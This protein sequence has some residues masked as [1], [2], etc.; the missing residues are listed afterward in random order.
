MAET[1][2]TLADETWLF[3]AGVWLAVWAVAIKAFHLGFAG[4]PAH[5][6]GQFYLRALAAISYADVVFVALF[7]LGAR[8][9][10]ALFGRWRPVRLAVVATF[11]AFAAFLCLYAVANVLMF[12]IFGGFITY[13]LLAIV[14]D[15]RMLRSSVTT[16]LR[17]GVI[18]GLVC[19]PLAYIVLV[20]MSHRLGRLGTAR[21]TARLGGGRFMLA[22]RFARGSQL[23][24]AAAGALMLAWIAVGANA[25]ASRWT[26]RSDRPI[27]ENPAWVFVSSWWRALR[28]GD[29][30]EM[31]D[32]FERSDLA[33]FEP[34]GAQPFFPSGTSARRGRAPLNVILLVLESVGARWTSLHS[35]VYDGTTPSLVA[36]SS[37]SLVFDHFYAHIGR[38]SNSLVAML[39][40]AYPKLDFRDLTDEYP[41]L[42]GTSLANVFQGHG[43]R[44]AFLT[45]SDISWANWSTFLEGRGF[46]DIRD[47]HQLACSE[48]LSSWGV[49]DRCMFDGIQ[50]YIAED[51]A[52][53][54]FIMGWTQQTHHPYEPTPG[55]PLLDLVKEP[56]A[57][58]YDLNRYLNVLHETDRHLGRM[59]AGLRQA[60]LD[61]NTLV[62]VVGD[63]G[64][65]FG[66]PHEGTFMQ[67]RTMY[68][69]DGHVP[70]L[71][72]SPGLYR[73]ARRSN[74]IGGH[75]DLA[76][77]ITELAG[78]PPAADWQ[79]RSLID[80]RHFPRAYFY[81][82]EDRF[83]LGVREDRWK[84]IYD[85]REAVEELYDL[86]RDPNEQ[87]NLA[88]LDPVRSARLRQRLAAWTEA[89]HRRYAV[90]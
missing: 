60:G 45:P 22:G 10:L 58:E 57:D 17:P 9:M 52:R 13:P 19:L 7:W 80:G 50:A 30:V 61:Q 84:Y 4:T 35:P 46:H 43:Y 15:V 87:H 2:R 75:V 83:K 64:Q 89:N 44:T 31:G 20:W 71:L 48:P 66:Y 33:D 24:I 6:V 81:V 16:Y 18:A 41:R 32:R 65:A 29:T 90:P 68:E 37:H 77:T 73:S 47:E 54:F 12:G 72:W 56:I 67:G 82:A 26:T 38:S 70:L 62:V 23:R 36:E 63:H 59:L 42:P 39:L 53:P 8:A 25:Y 88:A 74:T 28:A 51:P 27:A 5:E 85:L 40:S 11:T 76:P 69:E 1:N 78:L 49:E 14:G 79:G 55:V 34:L 21:S 86:E 3:W